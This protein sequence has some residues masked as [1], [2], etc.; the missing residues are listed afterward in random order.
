METTSPTFALILP[1]PRA[2]KLKNWPEAEFIHFDSD[3][4]FSIYF[5]AT[6]ILNTR[7]RV[8]QMREIE[9][10]VKKLTKKEAICCVWFKNGVTLNSVYQLLNIQN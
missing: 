10:M 6:G 9:A 3:Y 4:G 5:I 7:E 2:V 1:G 8:K